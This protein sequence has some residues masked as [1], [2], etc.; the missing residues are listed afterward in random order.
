MVRP[1]ALLENASA[2]DHAPHTSLEKLVEFDEAAFGVIGLETALGLTLR[3][4]HEGQLTLATAIE[5]MTSG[6]ARVLGLPGGTLPEGSPADITCID[7]ERTWTVNPDR[8]RSETRNTPFAG[9]TLVG[10]CVLTV[11][12]A[13]I[14]FDERGRAS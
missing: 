1:R 5:R 14:I 7:L 2:T 13:K 11:R 4:V 9:Q 12:S 8:G 10:K 3:L 6:P